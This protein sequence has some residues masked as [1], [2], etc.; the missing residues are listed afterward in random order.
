VD[1]LDVITIGVL[2]FVGV[3]L[4]GGARR[5]LGSHRGRVLE[6][7]RGVRLRHLGWSLVAMGLVIPTALAL[8]SLPVLELGWWSMI[9][10]E[11]NPALGATNRTAGTPWELVIPFVFCL[12]LLPG[13]PLFA[14]R[15]EEWFRLGA[16][17]RSFWGRRWRDVQFGMV[18][19]VVGIPMG[20]ALALSIGGIVFTERYLAG[21]ARRHSQADAVDE[22]TRT[23]LTYN[24]ILIGLLLVSILLEVVA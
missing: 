22:S 21:Y 1:P 17:R 18:H 8:S 7:W 23:H 5:S 12:F 24:S 6:L 10:G 11:G 3:R 20:V 16:E 9:G 15:E 14:Q 19:A 2:A 13:V 4:V